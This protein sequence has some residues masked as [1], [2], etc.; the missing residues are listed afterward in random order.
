METMTLPVIL[1]NIIPEAILL[2]YLG[3]NLIGIKPDKKRVAI[4][5]ILQ[6]IV[7]YYVR[8]N[9]DFGLHIVVQYIS[10]VLVT[11]VVVK[12]RFIAAMISNL[13]IMIMA[14]LLEGSI[15]MIIPY[16]TGITFT[17]MM[18]REWLRIACSLPYL[19]ITLV[20]NYLVAKYDFTLEQDIKLLHKVNGKNNNKKDACKIRKEII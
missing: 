18:S 7:C 9:F 3:L 5:G 11:W 13:I 14:I 1:L 15:G 20:I 2:I 10:F 16:I 12:T 17:E 19:I 8:K 6:G 4:S